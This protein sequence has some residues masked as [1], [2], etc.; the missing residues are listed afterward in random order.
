M[1][2]RQLSKRGGELGCELRDH[3]VLIS[4]RVVPYLEGRIRV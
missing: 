2:A 1:T 3:R 4:G